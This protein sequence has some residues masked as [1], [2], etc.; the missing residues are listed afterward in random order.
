MELQAAPREQFR[1]QHRRLILGVSLAW[2]IAAGLM[3][4]GLTPILP[5]IHIPPAVPPVL[6]VG[7]LLTACLWTAPK[8]PR[9][10][11][12][13]PLDDFW[14]NDRSIATALLTLTLYEGAGTLAALWAIISHSCLSLGVSA[15]A[16]LLLTLCSPARLERR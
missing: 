10:P 9:R 7:I 11:A 4:A 5:D 16:I 14:R 13:M 2:A 3:L 8:I 1:R 12:A 6:C 15:L